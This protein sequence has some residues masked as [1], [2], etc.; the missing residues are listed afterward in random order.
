MKGTKNIKTRTLTVLQ[1]ILS[2]K[3]FSNL[4]LIKYRWYVLLLFCLALLYMT[5]HYYM[6]K[7]AM[8]I[9]KQEIAVLGMR[10]DCRRLKDSVLIKRSEMRRRIERSGIELKEP[11]RPAKIIKMD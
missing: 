4:I 5:V 2:G 9:G 8:E 1:D 10:D 3:L 11:D 6:E 7:T